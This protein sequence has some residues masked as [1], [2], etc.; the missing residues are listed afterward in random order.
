MKSRLPATFAA[1]RAAHRR[2]L[3]A[4]LC[5]G[6][7]SIEESIELAVA[8]AR[9]GADVLELGVPFSD[10]SADG[11]TIARAST[12]AIRAGATITKVIEAARAIRA[13]T[14]VPLVLFTYVNPVFITGEE[15]VI[16]LADAAGIDAILAVDLPPEE[17]RDLRRA[18]AQHG[19]AVIP[20][21]APTSDPD[22]VEVILREGTREPGAK[23]GF[24][25]YVSMTG[26]TGGATSD[27]AEA[28]GRAQAL[29]ERSGWPVVI[30][31]GIDGPARA[32]E[33]AGPAGHGPDGVVVGT[34]IV[35]RIEE[36][37]SP[38]ARIASV[39][40]LVAAIRAALDQPDA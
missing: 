30:G 2:A 39:S 36:G 13:R 24:I 16:A 7:P 34:A 37:D 18:A 22:R 3:V 19:L 40:E 33:A 15:R 27:L 23:V 10:P 35:R 20:L 12:R 14:E 11:P 6:D 21:V 32:R 38:A 8:A 4:Y 28:R 31:F 26:I 17:G 29:A 1:L 5:V 9:A 25:Y